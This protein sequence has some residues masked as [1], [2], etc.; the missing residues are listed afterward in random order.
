MS[1]TTNHAPMLTTQIWY[2]TED[3][4]WLAELPPLRGY[5]SG[6]SAAAAVADLRLIRDYLDAVEQPT[7]ENQ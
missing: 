5:G 3:D 1:D 2:D 7:G 6:K 4:L